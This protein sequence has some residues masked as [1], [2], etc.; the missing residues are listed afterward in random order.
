MHKVQLN[1]KLRD[2]RMGVVDAQLVHD[3][4]WSL[5]STF[6]Q[7][8][9]T[10]NALEVKWTINKL[11]SVCVD[12]ENTI[13]G[14]A[15]PATAVNL[16]EKPK[17]KKKNKNKAK[18]T[19]NFKPS[20]HHLHVWGCKAEAKIPDQ[21]REKLDPKTVS[22]YRFYAPHNSTRII[23]TSNAK[24][25]DEAYSTSNFRDLS[26]EFVELV[27]PEATVNRMPLNADTTMTDAFVQNQNNNNNAAA[28]FPEPQN[29]VAEEIQQPVAQPM[30]PEPQNLG[31]QNSQ[32][33]NLGQPQNIEQPPLRRS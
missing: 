6:S 1:G 31:P 8:R 14:E 7:L 22:C 23:E 30:Q 15:Q 13:R 25:R 10:Y 5:P 28:E 9:S 27:E 29:N 24:F 33:Q 26:S 12:E 18:Q 4:L 32:P 2:L 19:T 3:A 11:I 21:L 20:L 16:M 17:W